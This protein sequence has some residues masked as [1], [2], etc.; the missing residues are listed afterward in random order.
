MSYRW[1]ILTIF[2][3]VRVAMGFQFQSAASSSPFLIKAFGI[4]Y[5]TIGFLIGIY[6][7][8]GIA[9]AIPGGYLGRRFGE[10]RIIAFGL[11]MMTAGGIVSGL[12]ETFE[13]VFAGRVVA[14]CGVVFLFVMMTKTIGDWFTGRGR[15]LSMAIFLNGWPVGMGIALVTQG[16]MA[17]GWGWEAIYFATAAVC[18][19]AFV[20]LLLTYK[21][22]PASEPEYAASGGEP[23][24]G[25]WSLSA[26][27]LI[28]VSLAGFLWGAMNGS[29]AI[30]ASFAPTYL[31][32]SGGLSP[33]A[34]AD[35]VSYSTW[36]AILG[37]PL[38]GLVAATS[39]RPTLFLVLT[40]LIGASA[41]LAL[42]VS[43]QYLGLMLIIGLVTFAGASVVVAMP[44][45]L[46]RPVN[47]APGLGV[48]YAWWYAGIA[49]FP[50]LAGWTVDVSGDPVAAIYVGSGLVFV[51]VAAI[52]PIRWLQRQYPLATQAG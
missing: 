14:G 37:V 22:A 12:A 4:D 46:T 42:T 32:L 39:G 27:E 28:G 20:L 18:A 34:A 24:P 10:K 2:V 6:L 9:I 40:M 5:T 33:N 43:D 17:Q 8:P 47:R 16:R 38:G 3:L 45:E 48:F 36:A 31:N 51:C 52:L 21:E 35:M 25:R 41:Y 13:L 29:N 50:M 1:I 15:F 30:L 23:A 11:A 49:G 44:I 19:A 26:P 7:V